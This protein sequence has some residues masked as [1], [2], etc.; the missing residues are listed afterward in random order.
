MEKET[1]IKR[2]YWMDLIKVISTILIVI[3]HSI[4]GE[5]MRI[6]PEDM[7]WK[8]LNLFFMLS[9]CAV[10]VFVI[11]SGI[12]M[13]RRERTIG[14][15]WK[16][17]IL[18]LGVV[19]ASWMFLYG[20]INAVGM[21][22]EGGYEIS[23]IVNSCFKSILFGEYHTWFIMMLI[24]LYMVTPLVYQII[25]KE[26]SLRYFII[27]A[28]VF[29]YVFP[30]LTQSG[31]GIRLIE[32]MNQLDVRMVTGYLFYYVIGY[33]MVHIHIAEKYMKW[34]ATAEGFLFLSVYLI[35]NQ[36]SAF[37]SEPVQSV[38][39]NFSIPGVFINVG[40]VIVFRYYVEKYYD[41]WG[42]ESIRK[43]TTKLSKLGI[44]VYLLHPQLLNYLPERMG[45][46]ILFGGLTV[47]LLSILIVAVIGKIPILNKLFI[48]N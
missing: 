19:Y 22:A 16:K 26:E 14:E 18:S 21:I 43:W 37:Q 27:L 8:V 40:F 34:F 30:T 9:R 1:G 33:Y 12:G 42:N 45:S 23:S 10:P 44:G 35:S 39:D 38:Y 17:N 25:Q 20:C 28:F 2:E 13:L 3:Q 4:S 7:G 36:I 41:K 6:N 47:W 11:C 24:G 32:N 5:W 29:S 15:I 46:K 48:R 31:V